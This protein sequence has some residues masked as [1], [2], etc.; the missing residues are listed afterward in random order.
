MLQT[1]F[2]LMKSLNITE[3]AIFLIHSV[4]FFSK[5][6]LFDVYLISQIYPS[7]L[8]FNKANSS[9]TEAPFFGF[10]FCLF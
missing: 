8:Q 10:A 5:G 4:F 6:N 7:E 1:S 9:E 2:L 3:T